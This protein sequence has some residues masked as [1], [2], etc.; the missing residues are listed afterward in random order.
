[1]RILVTGI[2]G[3]VGSHLAEFLLNRDDSFEVFG[4]RRW[5]SR[6]ENI[7]H[8]THKLNLVECDLNDGN[9]VYQ[10]MEKVKPAWIFHLAAQSYV[11]VSW[12]APADTIRNNVIGQLNILESIR[13]LDLAPRMQIAGSSE[14]YGLVYPEETPIT[15]SNPLRPMSPYGVSKVG[16]D[17]LAYQY[18]A[19]YGMHLVITRAF[20]HSGPRRGHVFVESNFARQIIKITRGEQEPVI[21]VGNLD[22]RRDYTDVT[23]VVRAYFL[24]LEKGQPGQVYNICSG[25]AYSIREI[26]EML[27]DISGIDVEVKTDPARLRPSDVPLLRG[28]YSRFNQ[29]TGWKPRVPLRTTLEK[30]LD[31]W[32]EKLAESD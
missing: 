19:S 1:M 5:R 4:T 32:K 26:L 16:Q 31:Y 13:A 25:T 6:M 28:D 30:V 17:M 27:I 20:N 23:D 14:E 9:S 21:K 8:L 24:A 2:T 22:A 7:E 18:Y 10:M 11:P 29:L 3:F 15:E 12:R